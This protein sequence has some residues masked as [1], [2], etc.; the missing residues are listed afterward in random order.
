MGF[1]EEALGAGSLEVVPV[2]S[3]GVSL[4]VVLSGVLPDVLLA[5]FEGEGVDEVL[6]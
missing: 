1:E 2:F 4:V 6:G 5:D 3:G